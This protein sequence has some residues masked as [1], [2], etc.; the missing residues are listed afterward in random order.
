MSKV[1][2]KQ[3]ML[4]GDLSSDRA[5]E[6][7]PEEPVC[8]DCIEAEEARGEDSRIVS[9]GDEV[10]DPEAICALCDCGFDD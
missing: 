9:V 5:S 8:T 6:Q 4:W 2:M 3:C 1:K 7:Y 10:T